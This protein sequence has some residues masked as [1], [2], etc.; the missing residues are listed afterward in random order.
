MKKIVM[1][2]LCAS[3]VLSPVSRITYAAETAETVE[4]TTKTRLEV[5]EEKEK[6]N[7]LTEDEKTELAKLKEAAVLETK[8]KELEA[9]VTAKTITEAEK[10]ELDKAKAEAKEKRISFLEWKD[11][12]KIITIEEKTELTALRK[13]KQDAEL[14]VKKARLEE[15]EKKEKEETLTEDEK[16]ELA[17]LQKELAPAVEDDDKK[18]SS[19][20]VSPVPDSITWTASPK[21]KRSRFNDNEAF[22]A[23]IKNGEIILEDG[24]SCTVDWFAETENDP[25]ITNSRTGGMIH[26]VKNIDAGTL[27]IHQES[28]NEGLINWTIALAT[29]RK[30]D[31]G[32]IYIE[33]ADPNWHPIK[34]SFRIL[35]ADSGAK[36]SPFTEITGIRNNGKELYNIKNYITDYK[37]EWKEEDGVTVLTIDVDDMDGNSSLAFEIQGYYSHNLKDILEE[38]SL[39]GGYSEDYKELVKY[40]SKF[41]DPDGE[42]KNGRVWLSAVFTA[43]IENCTEVKVDGTPT[44][45]HRSTSTT[46]GNKGIPKTSVGGANLLPQ[47]VLLSA[48][49]YLL[50]KNKRK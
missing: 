21:V 15:L 16:K 40:S 46:T 38:Y 8:I 41:S 12:I 27:E 29:S 10:A 2:I 33:F 39:S 11:S 14:A 20:T 31:D 32:K 24:K 18:D 7:T 26:S 50:I 30:L 34:E 9:K 17:A 6:T 42:N 22:P 37:A 36:E 5:L 23:N 4:E 25:D 1:F 43:D 13:E 3:L 44:S 19:E 35:K 28:E 49:A 45:T 47:I 48:G